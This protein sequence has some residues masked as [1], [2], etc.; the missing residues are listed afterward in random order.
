MIVIK[1]GGSLYNSP[2]LQEWLSVLAN[3]KKQAI[4]IVPGGGPFAEQVR[5][6]DKQCSLPNETTHAMA[7]LGM[8]QY[9]YMFQGLQSDLPLLSD[10]EEISAKYGLPGS[11]I[12]L[13][14]EEVIK[15]HELS[16]HWQTTS[17]SI[18]LWLACKIKASQLIVVKSAP[19]QNKAAH[20]L[21][22]SDIVDKHFQPML[23]SYAGTVE[24]MHA[25]EASQLM[26]KITA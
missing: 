12:W 20:E 23:T 26:D 7:V 21:I 15:T 6:V 22:H 2:Y 4:I 16:R 13:P 10:I 3:Q 18:A 14:Y 17:D 19:V 11:Y 25:S 24:F 5:T 1:I 8:Q 9:A